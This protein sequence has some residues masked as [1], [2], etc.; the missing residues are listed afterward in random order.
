ME[1]LEWIW[2]RLNLTSDEVEEI[3]VADEKLEE[4]IQK[5]DHCLVRKIHMERSIKRDVL[6]TTM[7]K[8]WQTSKTFSVQNIKPNLF[9]ITFE[10]M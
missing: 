5:G 7:Q 4:E 2:Q 9:L 3:K 10:T 8:V 6:Q 1:E